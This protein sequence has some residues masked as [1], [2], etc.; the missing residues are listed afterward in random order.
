MNP[1]YSTIEVKLDIFFLLS[2]LG[3]WLIIAGL[4]RAGM[5]KEEKLRMGEQDKVGL[6][7]PEEKI[8]EAFLFFSLQRQDLTIICT[9]NKHCLV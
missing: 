5:V 1:K 8:D 2:S 4:Q 3:G 7:Y 6:K 9:V